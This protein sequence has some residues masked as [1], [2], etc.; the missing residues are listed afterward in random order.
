[1]TRP[2][3]DYL[4]QP[5]VIRP[6]RRR[7]RPRVL[8][9]LVVLVLVLVVVGGCLAVLDGI[10]RSVQRGVAEAEQ[11]TAPR[12]VTEGRAFTIGQHQTLAG[13]QVEEFEWFGTQEFTVVAKVRNVSTGTSTAYVHFKFLTSS[14]EVLGNVRC[15]S[16]DLE[17]GQ[18]QA[19]TCDPDGRFGPFARV[20]AEATF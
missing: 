9:V 13:W 16:G 3:E 11:R 14:G 10:S 6:E 8:L 15:G 7:R 18:T 17:P 2:P 20:T 19:L 5:Y 12:T 1:M 4:G